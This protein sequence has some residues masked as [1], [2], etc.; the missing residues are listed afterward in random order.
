MLKS[1]LWLRI[2][3]VLTL[4]Y[5]V[6]HTIGV[7]WTP[8]T[9]PQEIAVIDA[10]KAARFTIL[11]AD[12]TYWNFYLGFGLIISGYLLVQA[13]VLWQLAVIERRMPGITR[14][15]SAGFCISFLVN[16]FFAWRYFFIAPVL[17]AVAI[18]I[19]LAIAFHL[20]LR[21]QNK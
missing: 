7:P 19:C 14:T 20:S 16:A 17:F 2:A 4:L 18:A 1:W 11:G 12:R 15:I 9:G 21:D 6:A 3:A 8:V 10:M 13:I 5:C